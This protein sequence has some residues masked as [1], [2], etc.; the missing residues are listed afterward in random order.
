LETRPVIDSLLDRDHRQVAKT[1]N[2]QQYGRELH[3]A[4]HLMLLHEE[5]VTLAEKASNS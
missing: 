2:D 1:E 5:M 3:S 4:F